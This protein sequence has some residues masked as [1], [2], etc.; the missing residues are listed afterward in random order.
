MPLGSISA[1]LYRINVYLRITTPDGVSSSVT[2]FVNFIDDGVTCTMTGV[3]MTSDAIDEP[4]SQYFFVDVDSPGPI[5]FG[6]LYASNT[7]NAATYKAV[8]VA[9]RVQ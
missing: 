5:S 2:P 7:P 9:E 4:S 3:A 6:T 8:V 1:G